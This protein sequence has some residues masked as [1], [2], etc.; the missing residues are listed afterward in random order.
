MVYADDLHG[1][2]EQLTLVLHIVARQCPI[3][4]PSRTRRGVNAEPAITSADNSVGHVTD[5]LPRPPRR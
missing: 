5:T 2:N 3:R 1:V 4:P